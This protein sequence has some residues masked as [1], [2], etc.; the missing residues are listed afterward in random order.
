MYI[1]GERI[2]YVV[3]IRMYSGSIGIVVQQY[4]CPLICY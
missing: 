4:S 2:D 3:Y 1:S